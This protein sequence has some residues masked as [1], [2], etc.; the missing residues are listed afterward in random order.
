MSFSTIVLE[1]SVC[2]IYTTIQPFSYRDILQ[3]FIDSIW[4]DPHSARTLYMLRTWYSANLHV[5]P[6]CT[7][8][9][10][11]RLS[12]HAPRSAEL[13]AQGAARGGYL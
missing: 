11:S 3:R 2:I 9:H 13:S 7:C 6:T 10:G 1:Y 12:A 5:I 4:A 8:P